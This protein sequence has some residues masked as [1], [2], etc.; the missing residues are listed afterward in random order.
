MEFQ[1]DSSKNRDNIKKHGLSFKEASELFELPYNLILE[2]YD[3]EHCCNEDRIISIGPI[4]RGVIVVVS[5]ERNEGNALRLISAR[6]ATKTE[7]Q[8]YEQAIAGETYD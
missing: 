2:L 4:H 7:Q 6:F 1:W 8:R 5:V 3:F